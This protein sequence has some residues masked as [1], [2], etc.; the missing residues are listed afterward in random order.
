MG[1]ST[2]EGAAGQRLTLW[3][4]RCRRA[5]AG[6]PEGSHEV[7]GSGHTAGQLQPW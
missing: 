2:L 5:G 7:Q 3:G 6:W 4:Q 1:V